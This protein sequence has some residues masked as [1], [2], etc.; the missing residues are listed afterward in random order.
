MQEYINMFKNYVNFSD[1]TNKRGFWM[2]ALIN[3]VIAVVLYY[4]SQWLKFPLATI[5]SLA[6]FLPTIALVVRRLRDGGKK[7][8][9]YLLVLI[10]IIGWIMLII[11]FCKPSIPADGVP[12]V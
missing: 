3:W 12:T 11:Q 8:T 1:R 4:V 9:Y 5:Y 2:A 10:P 6:I 7:W